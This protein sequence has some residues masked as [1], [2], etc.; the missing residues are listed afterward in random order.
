MTPRQLTAYVEL[1]TRDEYKR[2][3]RLFNMIRS[4]SPHNKNFRK[5]LKQMMDVSD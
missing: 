2:E 4:A 3:V 5:Q 1:H